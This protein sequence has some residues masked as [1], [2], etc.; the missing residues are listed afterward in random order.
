MSTCGVYVILKY[1]N[2]VVE[3]P[4]S[5]GWMKWQI[6]KWGTCQLANFQL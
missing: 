2:K 5:I 6:S 4:T 1:L 3:P